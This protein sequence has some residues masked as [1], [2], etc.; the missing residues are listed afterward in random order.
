MQST[1]QARVA[2]IRRIFL[3]LSFVKAPRSYAAGFT[4]ARLS[5]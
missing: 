5:S 1:G 2:G 3:F 4:H